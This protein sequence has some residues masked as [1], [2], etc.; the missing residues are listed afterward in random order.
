MRGEERERVCVCE[1]ERA[2]ERER[3]V[4]LALRSA[5]SLSLFLHLSLRQVVKLACGQNHALALRDDGVLYGWGRGK[6]PPKRSNHEIHYI[7]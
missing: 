6:V 3:D 2:R 5:R 1:R 7:I 4:L